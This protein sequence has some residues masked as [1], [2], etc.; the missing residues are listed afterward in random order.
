MNKIENAN[1]IKSLVATNSTV[2]LVTYRGS[3][4]PFCKKY[5]SKL[6]DTIKSLD[7]NH[8]VIGICS[9]SVE[10][11]QTHKKNLGLEFELISD[12]NLLMRDLYKVNTCEKGGNEHLQPSIFIFKD[13]VKV[14][15]W[16]Q[17]PSLF[18]NMGGAINRMTVDD[19]IKELS[20]LPV[21]D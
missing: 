21:T 7:S 4:C 1:D 3:W 5:L 13:G 17:T 19:A 15:E 14:F 2:V 8:T 18:K 20:S 9:E 16:I 12:Q 6:S 11:C 10:E